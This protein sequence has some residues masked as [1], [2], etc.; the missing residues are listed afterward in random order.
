MFRLIGSP[1]GQSL[2]HISG[3][4]NKSAHFWDP[5]MFTKVGDRKYRYVCIIVIAFIL[6]YIY[7]YN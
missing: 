3:T 2:N 1:L 6:K 7:I 5:K 4:S